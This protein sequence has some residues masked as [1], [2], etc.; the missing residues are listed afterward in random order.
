MRRRLIALAEARAL[1]RERAAAERDALDGFLGRADEAASLA[2][3]VQNLIDELRRRPALIAAGAAFMVALRP[4]RALSWL[5]KG[6]SAWR[7]YRGAQ[8]WF[9]S[10]AGAQGNR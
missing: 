10:V 9:A 3:R 8:R 2:A 1:L 5:A 6:W 7:L 4:K